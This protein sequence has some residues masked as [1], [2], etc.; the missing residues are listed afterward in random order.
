M[1][2]G[3][4]PAGRA[5][6]GV[7]WK[8]LVRDDAISSAE[9]A[10][11]PAGRSRSPPRSGSSP[12]AARRDDCPRRACLESAESLHWLPR[13]D[14]AC[15][16][17]CANSSSWITGGTLKVWCGAGEGTV[18]SSPLAPS[19]TRSVAFFFEKNTQWITTPRKISCEAPNRN[20]PIELI[21][22]KLANA[23]L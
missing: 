13:S 15:T 19:H 2:L 23:T 6:P 22:L 3:E 18:H 16:L 14:Q 21:M 1:P 11:T 8:R 9:S 10:G 5:D 4:L 17:P 12:C 7:K 20:P